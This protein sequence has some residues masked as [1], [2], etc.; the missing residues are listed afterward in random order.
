MS[1][2]RTVKRSAADKR[3][4]KTDWERV[5]ALS[6]EDIE[7]AALSDADAQPSTAAFWK[8]ATLYM[9]GP[10]QSI[11]LRLDRDMLE[12]YKQQGRGYQTRMNAVL[13]AYMDNRKQTET[14]EDTRPTT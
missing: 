9:P 6:E 7:Q 13:R 1:E 5:K 8:D 2:K 10:K 4:G 12:W 14:S 11:T 3:K